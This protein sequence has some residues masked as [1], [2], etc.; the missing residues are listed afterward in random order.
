M[1]VYGVDLVGDEP[2]SDAVDA[3]Y[4]LESSGEPD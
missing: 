1:L 4:E 3:K 2:R